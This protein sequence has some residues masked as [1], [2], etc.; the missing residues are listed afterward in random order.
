MPISS[1][2]SSRNY[3]RPPQETLLE[4]T[5]PDYSFFFKLDE[6]SEDQVIYL[7]SGEFEQQLSQLIHSSINA[8]TLKNR[9]GILD[10]RTVYYFEPV[11]IIDWAN[12]KQ[13]ELSEDLR[14][15]YDTQ[16]KPKPNEL[17]DFLNPA[18]P[19]HSHE[20][21]IAVE[22]WGEVLKSNPAKPKTGTRKQLIEKWLKDRDSPKLSQS[23]IERITVM[24]N[25]DGKGGA[26][27][28]EET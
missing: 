19:M 9:R 25:P 28:T 14:N 4:I 23:A 24:L 8:K 11:V 16:S 27:A 26:P 13:I 21:K 20:L 17:P 3:W 2:G 6:W 1:G 22:A 5:P 15:W 10:L 7:L 12:S 18:H